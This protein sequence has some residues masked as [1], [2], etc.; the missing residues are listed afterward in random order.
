MNILIF[1]PI[2]FLQRPNIYWNFATSPRSQTNVFLAWSSTQMKRS[3]STRYWLCAATGPSIK[4]WD[5]ESKNQVEELRPEVAGSARGEPPVCTALSWSADGQTLFAGYSDNL[6]RVWQV[7]GLW[8][9][10]SHYTFPSSLQL[11][12]NNNFDCFQVS[13]AS[14]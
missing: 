11:L 2:I 14:R 1:C 4:V 13:M 12:E 7:T 6:I 9:N 3:F 10:E 8:K 5:L